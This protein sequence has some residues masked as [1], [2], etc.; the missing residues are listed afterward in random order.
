LI[1]LFNRKLVKGISMADEI[2]PN[3][4]LGKIIE[5]EH[6]REQAEFVPS[7]LLQTLLEVLNQREQEVIA[8]RHGLQGK[9]KETLEAIGS[10]FHVTRERIRQI[11]N[12]ALRHV[13]TSESYQHVAERMEQAIGRIL[14]IY[15]GVMEESHLLS[16]ALA[17]IPEQ[18]HEEPY[19]LFFLRAVGSDRVHE[20]FENEYVK[21][22]WRLAHADVS[23]LHAHIQEL[24][25]IFIEV[26]S[27][28][29][30]DHVLEAL[31][32]RQ[33]Y[34][35]HQHVLND[36]I[37]RA[38]LYLGKHFSQNPFEQWGL[39]SWKTITPKRMG[40]KIFL[41]LKK[42]GEPLHYRDITEKINDYCFD[43]KKAH[44]PTVHNELILDD[45][46]VLVGR[47]IYALQDWGFEP[48]IVADVIDR[49]LEEAGTPFTREEII[50][51]VL[52]R[53]VVKRGTIYLALADKKRFTRDAEGRYW[54]MG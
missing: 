22:G 48:G 46:Y 47:G 17:H 27:P 30:F 14:D 4:L 16:E 21:T 11:E 10:S 33:F 25:S 34:T 29:E 51:R 52:E 32:N 9:K 54:K 12:T 6:E 15:G 8:R 24:K 18:S 38:H 39:V 50:Q 5:A 26:E 45:R 53:R 2:Q 3:T 28:L 31:R 19:V 35:E 7:L 43:H 23:F 42:H 1:S 20:V 44:A 13:R 49:V 40:D 37:T 41:V 36:D